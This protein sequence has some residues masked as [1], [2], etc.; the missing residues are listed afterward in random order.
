MLNCRVRELAIA[1]S[2]FV[3][4]ICKCSI[5]PNTICSHSYTRQYYAEWTVKSQGWGVV[6]DFE[7]LVWCPCQ[8]SNR[9]YLQ[10]NITWVKFLCPTMMVKMIAGYNICILRI[11]FICNDFVLWSLNFQQYSNKSLILDYN[12]LAESSSHHMFPADNATSIHIPWSSRWSFSQIFF[13]IVVFIS[14]F[15]LPLY[16]ISP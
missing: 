12:E 10:D 3:V 5:N 13:Q 8:D 4:T 2:L 15:H 14:C 11:S 1:L 16:T 7:P 9:D 6:A